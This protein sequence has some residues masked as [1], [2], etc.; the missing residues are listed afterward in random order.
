MVGGGA[1]TDRVRAWECLTCGAIR[2]DAVMIE[3]NPDDHWSADDWAC[4]ACGGLVLRTVEGMI[5]DVCGRLVRVRDHQH[6][7]RPSS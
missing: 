7:P 1:V 2:L 3:A 4:A 5:C 6:A